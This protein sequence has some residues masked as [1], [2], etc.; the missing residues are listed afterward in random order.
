MAGKEE[1][2]RVYGKAKEIAV[3][4]AQAATNVE[5]LPQPLAY[6]IVAGPIG[7]MADIML[8]SNTKYLRRRLGSYA[9][10]AIR[11]VKVLAALEIMNECNWIEAEEYDDASKEIET[12]SKMLWGLVK[13]IRKAAEERAG[14]PG[15]DG[16]GKKAAPDAKGA[17]DKDLGENIEDVANEA[18]EDNAVEVEEESEE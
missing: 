7:V 16:N 11:T 4:L 17:E 12:L 5:D 18:A 3:K 13:N 10:A 6:I 1:K 15:K 2:L 8:G 9:R 14:A